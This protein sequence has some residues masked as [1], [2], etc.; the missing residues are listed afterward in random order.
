[1]SEEDELVFGDDEATFMKEIDT[2]Y[3]A[4]SLVKICAKK[5]GIL[6]PSTEVSLNKNESECLSKIL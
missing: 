2:F 4:F 3:S 1:M 5:C 6:R